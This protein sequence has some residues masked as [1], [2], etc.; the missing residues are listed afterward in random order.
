MFLVMA[1]R[2]FQLVF[3]FLSDNWGIGHLFFFFFVVYL[4]SQYKRTNRDSEFFQK[5]ISIL[6]SSLDSSIGT[7]LD[8][9]ARGPGFKSRQEPRLFCICSLGQ[10]ICYFTFLNKKL[11][12]CLIVM[13]H[14]CMK[15]RRPLYSDATS[16]DKF[17]HVYTGCLQ[18]S[19]NFFLYLCNF[20]DFIHYF[21]SHCTC[22]FDCTTFSSYVLGSLQLFQGVGMGEA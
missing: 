22:F 13:Y 10:K 3:Q 16:L 14:S 11:S 5:K 9:S 21:H 2:F 19:H 7:A 20:Q 4:V 12:H 8:S 15:G 17:R 1:E 18:R 6:P